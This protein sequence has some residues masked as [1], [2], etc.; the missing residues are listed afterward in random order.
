MDQL[1]KGGIGDVIGQ[2]TG[3]LKGSVGLD[4]RGGKGMQGYCQQ[5]GCGKMTSFGVG[6]VSSAVVI[7]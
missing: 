2:A 4:I 6:G 5:G 7:H 1:Q 3:I